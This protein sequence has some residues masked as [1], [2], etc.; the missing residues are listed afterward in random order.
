MRTSCVWLAIALLACN[1][2]KDV[3]SDQP[4][5]S[6][7]VV[8]VSK[9]TAGLGAEVDSALDRVREGSPDTLITA[10]GDTLTDFDGVI[11]GGSDSTG[12]FALDV[13]SVNNTRYARIKK[14]VGRTADGYLA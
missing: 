9:D 6:T 8:S 7:P 13:Y 4:A 12:W 11:I 1:S 10:R 3:K 14:S 2:K 5:S